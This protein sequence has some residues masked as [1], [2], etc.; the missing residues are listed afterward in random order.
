M[1]YGSKKEFDNFIMLYT[2]RK[3]TVLF[4]N[5]YEGKYVMKKDLIFKIIVKI[6]DLTVLIKS[7]IKSI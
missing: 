5:R 4:S 2:N 6:S 7:P 1:L 3:V